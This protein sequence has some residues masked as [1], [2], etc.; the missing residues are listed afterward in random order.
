[1]NKRLSLDEYLRLEYPFHVIP[2]ETGGYTILFPNLP[3]C[4]TCVDTL[5]ELPEMVRDAREA[6]IKTA[7]ARGMDIPP[8]DNSYSLAFPE[9]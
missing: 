9:R 1:M 6:W 2:D 4:M 3:G 5:E 7:Y 8:P